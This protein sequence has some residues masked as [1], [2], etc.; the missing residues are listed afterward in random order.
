MN[1]FKKIIAIILT[2]DLIFVSSVFTSFAE[3]SD[4]SETVVTT[5]ATTEAESETTTVVSETE[6]SEETSSS[7]EEESSYT[8]TEE[9]EN[10]SASTEEPENDGESTSSLNVEN[11]TTE[12]TTNNSD[13]EQVA[14]A[15]EIVEEE[16]EVI[17]TNSV[18]IKSDDETFGIDELEWTF[19]TFGTGVNTTNNGHNGEYADGTVEVFSTNKKGKLVPAS[20]DG[21]AFYYTKINPATKNFK[22][23]ADADV[24]SWNLSNGQD[25]FGLMACDRVG[26]NGDST[27]FWNNSYMAS[28]TKVEYFW[29]GQSVSTSGDKIVMKLGVGS[30]EKKGVT[31]DNI[32]PD[33]TLDDMSLFSSTMTTLDTTCA[34]SG[35]GTYN[36]VGNYTNNP[37][38]IGTIA[39]PRT[40][41][42]LSI[43]KNNTGYFV[44]Y[45]NPDGDVTTKKYYDPNVLNY[46]DPD[47]VY[48]GFFAARNA[49]VNFTNISFTTSDPST[50]PEPED[51]DL[52]YV[53]PNYQVISAS[54]ANK[55]DYTLMFLSNADGT[56]SVNNN[57]KDVFSGAV[58]ANEALSV[59]TEIVKG[60]NEFTLVMTPDPNYRPSEHEKLSSYDPATI[61]HK[62]QFSD[63]DKDVVFVS[64]N[65]LP[66]N[67]GSRNK[68][69]T[70]TEA[71]KKAMPGQ[72][73]YL[74][75]GAYKLSETLVI[76]REMNGTKSK[77]INLY[78]DPIAKSRP[79]LDFQKVGG[80][81]TLAGDYWHL[82][83][84]DITKTADMQK[85][86]IIAGSY[87]TVEL[88]NAYRNGNTGIQLSRYKGS[89]TRSLWPVHNLILNCTSYSNA[90]QG[91]EDA[92]GF[93]AKITCGEG[94]VFDGCIS[95][96]NAD[97]GWDLFAKLET[98][99]IGQV[100]IK[101]SIAYKSG[102]I[103]DEDGKERLAG[104]GN[105]FKLGGESIT[106]HHKLIN[107]IA[108]A[109]SEKGIDSN[110]CP[111]IIVERCT[112]FNNE[113]H[114]VALYTNTA[115]NTDFDMAGVLSYKNDN[116]VE[117][118]ISP[119]GTQDT[120]KIYKETNYYYKDGKFANSVGKEV[121][122]SWFVSIDIE[123]A[124]NGGITRNEDGSINMNGF[125]EL[126]G[127]VPNGVGAV[128][129]KPSPAPTPSG[130]GTGGGGDSSG[131]TRG[132]MGD[133]TKNPAYANLLNNSILN[134]TNNIPKSNLVNDVALIS[135]LKSLP[136]N[137][138]SN[139]VNMKDDKGNTGFGQWLRVPNTTTW[140]FLSGNANDALNPNSNYGFVSS[141]WYN[142]F[143]NG[144]DKWYHFDK[145]G[146]MQL[147]WYQE[148]GKMYYLQDNISDK[149]YGQLLT[150]NQI[151]NGN[152]YNFDETGALIK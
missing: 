124:L 42:H 53:D 112:S 129:T 34:S 149:W 128:F 21:L 93:A 19:S 84:F 20:T 77:S 25:G 39:N 44:S 26:V 54:V 151:I 56:L 114:N 35:A 99:S 88:V 123:S 119:V 50:D 58:T 126:T 139:Y 71:V 38:P 86:L 63:S 31:L 75:E 104:N 92:D 14:S 138:Q 137:V 49:D 98:G 36:L 127:N 18:A 12:N 134:T 24:I 140:Y 22:L 125:L 30:Q 147:G 73:I 5:I 2:I 141:G 120:K 95:A 46:L 59:M 82:K 122:E 144:E 65:G 96:Y 69:T 48:L 37:A 40:T 133:L 90:D 143:W 23:S 51:P 110:S 1:L 8:S 113:S 108:F 97:D 29:D 101:N 62:V 55:S 47:F 87:N 72:T 103:L 135:L 148:N 74:M 107:S 136:E 79:I 32:K 10:S 80:G 145:N 11:T 33:Y 15:S 100:V 66:Q 118:K 16:I 76:E 91:Y 13:N 67:D 89:D 146:L 60:D 132:P 130:G 45:T 70:I 121:D 68:P 27:T 115:S 111:D 94:N 17:L 117:E 6:T 83:G 152:I 28:V 43:E 3:N 109:N 81:V 41:F 9:E 85:G 57:G 106:G 102:Y 142:L 116:T 4:E 7:T 52:T 61:I 64:P 78:V 105:G 150:G 131:P